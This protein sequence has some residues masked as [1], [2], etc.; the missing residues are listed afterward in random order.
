MNP[1]ITPAVRSELA[2]SGKLREAINHSNFLLVNA[3]SPPGA[4]D[5]IAPDL[6][7]ELGKRVVIP[8]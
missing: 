5:S 6:A 4:P 7:L 2:P 8:G 3:D 1:Q